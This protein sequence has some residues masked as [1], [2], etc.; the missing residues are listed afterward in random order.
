MNNKIM[1]LCLCLMM[2][3]VSNMRGAE[4]EMTKFATTS[5]NMD[6]YISYSTA[7]GGGTA[8]PAIYNEQIRLYQNADGSG[9]GNITITAKSGAT[10]TE[11][12]I[13]SSQTT[14]IR[15]QVGE[16]I[17]TTNT[18]LGKDSITTISSLSTNSVTCHCYGTDSRTRLYINYLR[19]VYEVNESNTPDEGGNTPIEPQEEYWELVTNAASLVIDDQVVIVA[20]DI[21]CA[22]GAD[23]GNNRGQADVVKSNNTITFGEGVQM[24]TL[25]QGTIE[26][27]YALSVDTGYL[28]AASSDKN[29]LKTRATK[30]D[31]ASW[32]ITI[33][34]SIATI[35]AQGENERNLLKYNISAS[36]FSCY[37]SSSTVGDVTIYKHVGAISRPIY[38]VNSQ[39]WDNVYVYAWN[40][41]TGID[42]A[43]WPGESALKADYQINGY[44]VYYYVAEQGKYTHCIFNSYIGTQ[45]VDLAWNSGKYCYN[46]VWYTY[47]ELVSN[48][49]ND[50]EQSTYTVA[51]SSG[52]LGTHWDVT[53]T[54]NNMTQL[55]DG[56]YQLIK[57][58][59]ALVAGTYEY[60][61]VKDH[62]WNWCLPLYANEV[63]PID[64]DGIY[65]VTFTLDLTW[66]TISATAELQ[67][68]TVVIPQ[69]FLIGTMND[70]DYT[71]TQL[72][73]APDSLTASVAVVLNANT[74]Y[75]YQMVV[76]GNWFTSFDGTMTRDNCQNWQFEHI[77]NTNTYASIHTDI[78]GEYTFVWNYADNIV[79]VIY[80]DIC[81][82]V[83][84]LEWYNGIVISEMRTGW[85]KLSVS[86]LTEY[87]SLTS[88]SLYNYLYNPVKVSVDYYTACEGYQIMQ[89]T[90]T[91]F[92]TGVTT[93][94]VNMDELMKYMNYIPNIEFVYLYI[95]IDII[96]HAYQTIMDYVCEGTEY[97]DPI[98]GEGHLI[99]EPYLIWMDTV[100]VH[101]TL[102]SI[103]TFYITPIVA[104]EILNEYTLEQIGA[105][106]RIVAGH[107]VD[108]SGSTE[109]IMAYYNA[110]DT[111]TLADVL[112]VEW[113]N[114]ADVTLPCDAYS[115]AMTLLVTTAC[116]NQLKVDYE[117]P[118]VY[119]DITET[120]IAACGSYTW[121]GITYTE[122]GE[123]Y[124]TNDEGCIVEILYLTIL[125]T[126]VEQTDEATLCYGETYTWIDGNTY[127]QSG[128]YELVIPNIL[129][130]DSIIATL[131][132]TILPMVEETIEEATIY[133]GEY[134]IW[135]GDIYTK[136]GS[137]SITY[138]NSHGCD[139]TV[140]L[141][142]TVRPIEDWELL[143]EIREDLITNHTWEYPWNM[144][145][146]AAS[147]HGVTI[148]NGHVVDINLDNN[149]LT[150]TFPT[151]IL[152][153]PRL[154]YLS[155]ANNQ[156][157][158]DAFTKIQTD[159]TTFVAANPTFVSSLITLD[160]SYN[161][162]T[163]NVGL[164]AMMTNIFPNLNMLI[165]NN[166]RFQDV[167]PMLPKE[168][169]VD[170]TVQDIDYVIPT[171][172]SK[173][174]INTTQIP[175]ILLYD[176]EGQSYYTSPLAVGVAN[177]PWLYSYG[178]EDWGIIIDVQ[179]KHVECAN[180]SAY[181]GKSGDTLYLSY[182][183]AGVTYGSY[184]RMTLSFDMGDANFINGVDITDLQTT[185]LYAFDEYGACAFN[186]TAANT[187]T[188]DKINVQD[189]IRT[190]DIL[191]STNM[192]NADTASINSLPLRTAPAKWD[193]AEIIVENNQIKLIATQPIA[194]LRIQT[195]GD[196]QWQLNQLGL[197]QSVAD[198]KVVG[199]SLIGDYIPA[200]ETIL[201]TYQGYATV[202]IAELSNI[203]ANI[204]PAVIRN[205]NIPSGVDNIE[206]DSNQ[207]IYDVLG[208]KHNQMNY[209][210]LY[211]IKSNNQYI[212]VY[213]YNK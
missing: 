40:E 103:Y 47:D 164:L 146:G 203:E 7:K 43:T 76:D 194:A 140:T 105:I 46:D 116:D 208:R 92:D 45:T 209:N 19:V 167:A 36:V 15:W 28:Y 213:N 142:L 205:Q 134:Y 59:L 39:S 85:Y 51:G 197:E 5:A 174:D 49:N 106:P 86:S 112:H 84:E 24:L 54:T 52:L 199:Y 177:T 99:V 161:Q 78:A 17:D 6:E 3:V 196:I 198:N 88:V 158:G 13:G 186:F 175:T 151:K 160:I 66:Q 69:V 132:L 63:L 110:N 138:Q 183:Y 162:F 153:L 171:H 170:L 137:Y 89:G 147:L 165:A 193:E 2:F 139:S 136:G 81:S 27:T 114:G 169:L 126:T 55:E 67:K 123:Y 14:Q 64:K 97:I 91:R 102:D 107:P 121:N 109:A 1:L 159:M 204:V 178:E 95:S 20:K 31:N 108:I 9:G 210:G 115:H 157:I 117:F 70:W 58:D 4:V 57:T 79:S 207:E 179:E 212:K 176:H 187:Y 143:E 30:D 48:D 90:S 125:P 22:L 148:E 118:V 12:T 173:L 75:D 155:L 172:L 200:G 195:T 65:T 34:D 141:I 32:L 130:C 104:P 8:N 189:V 10:I 202:D 25:E 60:K 26:G 56:T 37:S 71:A 168:M 42:N 83:P 182:P 98:T 29:Q 156:L 53:D 150:G 154:E 145:A 184:C 113:I 128:T 124:L 21:A 133:D 33:T 129:G 62:S 120:H 101:E 149:G 72:Q 74:I 206:S 23:K 11:V 181:T 18:D 122:S 185:I 96:E 191:L 135:Q 44:D 144:S 38:F 61:V 16:T 77:E 192:T 100:H 35:Q 180:G 82:A 163:G 131:N 50:V 166:T 94:N 152:Q 93:V 211:I 119:V 111:E 87:A 41:E 188:D 80:P 127:T 73:L 190:V 68:E 201:G